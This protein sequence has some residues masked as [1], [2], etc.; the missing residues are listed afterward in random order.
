MTFIGDVK[1][2]KNPSLER[3]LPPVGGMLKEWPVSIG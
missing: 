1:T 3:I 2:F